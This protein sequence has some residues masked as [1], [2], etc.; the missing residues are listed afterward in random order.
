MDTDDMV[1]H[2]GK[3]DRIALGPDRPY[4]FGAHWGTSQE[5]F[6]GGRPPRPVG[7]RIA[8]DPRAQFEQIGAASKATATRE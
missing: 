8:V 5:Y 6:R 7:I 2:V 1:P 4:I 3:A